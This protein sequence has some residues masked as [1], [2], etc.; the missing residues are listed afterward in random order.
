MSL[1]Q[2]PGVLEFVIVAYLLLGLAGLAV[3]MG[4]LHPYAGADYAETA[5]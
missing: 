2:N 3:F 1:W 5:H 4:N